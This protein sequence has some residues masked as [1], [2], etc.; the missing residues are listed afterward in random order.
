MP[1]NQ[2]RNRPYRIIGIALGFLVVFLVVSGCSGPARITENGTP[3]NTLPVNP[4]PPAPRQVYVP[5]GEKENFTYWGHMIVINYVSAS[6]SQKI[7]VNI[8]GSETVI[9]RNHTDSPKGIDWNEGNLSF[10]L[11]PVVWEMRD[12]QRVPIYERTWNTREVYFEAGILMPMSEV[13]GG[14]HR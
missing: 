6:P 4:V 12:G 3:A 9:T 5:A 13:T 2:S 14:P 1:Q 8:D 11:K 7:L 10:T